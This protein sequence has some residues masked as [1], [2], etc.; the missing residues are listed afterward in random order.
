MS[1]TTLTTWPLIFNYRC[2]VLGNGFM[3]LVSFKGRVLAEQE[4][5][6]VWLS[7]VNPGGVAGGGCDFPSAQTELGR[8][9][10]DVL[11]DIAADVESF[12]AFAHAVEAFFRETDQA[13]GALWTA[14]RTRVRAEG[15]TGDALGLE[16]QYG[17]HEAQ[18]E[19]IEM[20]VPAQARPEQNYQ[21]MAALAA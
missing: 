3:A 11:F 5:G 8:C 20:Q 2:P 6:G 17:A 10:S 19:V 9:V 4:A 7:G 16:T 13:A 18:F 14:A 21:P 12:G 15:T 1:D